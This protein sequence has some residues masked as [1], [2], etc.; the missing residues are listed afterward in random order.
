MDN[1]SWIFHQ[2]PFFP[3][4]FFSFWCQDHVFS[5]VL[6]HLDF[7]LDVAV[8]SLKY[9]CQTHSLFTAW[10]PQWRARLFELQKDQHQINYE[11]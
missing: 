5:L 7:R 6:N 2:P 9:S 11:C 3:F 8:M 1:C 4:S 10:R